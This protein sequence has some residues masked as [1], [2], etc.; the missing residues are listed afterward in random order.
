MLNAFCIC[1]YREDLAPLA[2]EMHQVPTVST[3]R[4]EDTHS[5]GDVSP[6][7]LVE[8]INVDLAELFLYVHRDFDSFHVFSGRHILSWFAAL[9]SITIDDLQFSITQQCV[10][11]LRVG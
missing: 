4:V 10:E 1:I 6:Q 11:T 8:D 5:T 9:V 7:N 2:Q 3:P